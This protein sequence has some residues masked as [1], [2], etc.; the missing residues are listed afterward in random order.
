MRLSPVCKLDIATVGANK[1]RYRN[2]D[3]LQSSDEYVGLDL[4]GQQTAQWSPISVYDT[5]SI[6]LIKCLAEAAPV[7]MSI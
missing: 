5:M 3:S 1:M 6:F 4:R 7:P 2:Q